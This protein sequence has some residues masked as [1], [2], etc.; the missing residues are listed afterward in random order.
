MTY[1]PNWV[2]CVL[3]ACGQLLR[4]FEVLSLGEMCFQGTGGVRGGFSFYTNSVRDCCIIQFIT[5]PN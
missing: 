4:G 3:R 2:K 1:L 5:Q